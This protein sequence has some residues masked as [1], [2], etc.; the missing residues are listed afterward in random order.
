M[1]S[2][3]SLSARRLAAM[4]GPSEAGSGP[5]YRRLATQIRGAVMDGRIPTGTTLPSER[6]LAEAT[7]LSRT[8]TTRAYEV[9]RESRLV[10]T[11][12][13]S[14]TTVELP[15][16]AAGS[17]SMLARSPRHDGIA[18]T[19]AASEAPDGFAAL[20]QRAMTSLPAVLATDG[21]LPDGLPV[22]RERLAARYTRHGLPTDPEQIVV[23]TGAQS[24]LSLLVS[25]LVRPR[26]RV[27]VEGCGYPHSF[28]L[29][30]RAGARLLPLP[31]GVDP[32]PVEEI[33]RLAPVASLALLV[34]D[35]HNPTGQLMPSSTRREVAGILQRAGVTT[36]IDE[37]LRDVSLGDTPLPEHYAV[38][39]P[40]AVLVGSAAKSLWGGL[41]IGWIRAPRSLVPRLVQARM[42]RDLGTAA[43]DQLVMATALEDGDL[44]LRTRKADLRHRRDTL[45]AAV[46]AR[47][48]DWSVT[49]PEGGLTCWATLPAPL[50]SALVAVAEDEGLTLTPGPRFFVATPAAGER[51][52]R[53]PYALAPDL[54]EDAV[55]RLA[56]AWDRVTSGQSGTAR[57]PDAVDLIA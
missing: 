5:A 18:L 1:A 39:D 15:V 29:V 36:I 26:D 23:T 2:A 41:R 22:L 55:A 31:A 4:L 17:T 49:R 8:T 20:I 11:R 54:L 46:E 53:L 56:R 42:I 40:G 35:F 27:L 52:L 14:G 13:G 3:P 47:L 50:S 32:W 30:S 45:L 16:G 38:H 9:L 10:R 28:D 19:A 21:Y 6:S 7:G 34:V 57:D 48:P 33:A 44:D 37:T 51:R 25:V 12:Q 43:L 24:A